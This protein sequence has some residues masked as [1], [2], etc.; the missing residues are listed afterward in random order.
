M[1]VWGV[2]K[3]KSTPVFVKQAPL[4]GPGLRPGPRRL[5][6]FIGKTITFTKFL[7]KKSQSK[8]P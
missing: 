7:P 5:L 8:F 6:E 2:L 1:P 4:L 3:A